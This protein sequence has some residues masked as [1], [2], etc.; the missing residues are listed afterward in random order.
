MNDLESVIDTSDQRKILNTFTGVLSREAH[1]L[2]NNPSLLWQQ[3]HNRLQ[4]EDEQI[5][6]IL[7]EERIQRSKP[8]SIPW[9]WVKTPYRESKERMLTISGEFKGFSSCAISPDGSNLVASGNDNKLYLFDANSGKELFALNGHT[10][11]ISDC[12][13]SP[14]GTWF[15]SASYDNTIKIWDLI[16]GQELRTFTGHTS[17]VNCCVIGP[18]GRS[19]LSGS[20]DDTLRIWD[21]ESGKEIRS[22]KGHTL[23]RGG[24]R[25]VPNGCTI[26]SDGKY[27]VSACADKTIRIFSVESGDEEKMLTGHTNFVVACSFSPDN[28]RIV[29]ASR[30]K[31][32]RIWDVETGEELNVL[33]GHV[34]SVRDCVVS[35]D[36]KK[37]VSSSDDNNLKIW[38]I[39]T[40]KCIRTLIGHSAT[41]TGCA[42]SP[43]GSWILSSS[44][45]GTVRIWDMKMEA[46]NQN[47]IGHH[48]GV[49]D[50]AFSPDGSWFV[51]SGIDESIKIWDSEN[52]GRASQTIKEMNT[53]SCIVSKDSSKIF[54]A[55]HRSLMIIDSSSGKVRSLIKGANNPFTVSPD[56]QWIIS[57]TY[58]SNLKKWDA[59]TGREIFQFG[60]E[61]K[62]SLIC[63]TNPNGTKLV[64]VGKDQSI[65]VWDVNSG[66]ILLELKDHTSSINHCSFSLDGSSIVSAS[67]DNS[68]K[69][70]DLETGENKKEFIL[71]NS[72]TNCSISPD[73][74]FLIFTDTEDNLK[75]LDIQKGKELI[76]VPNLGHNSIAIHPYK[77]IAVCADKLGGLALI[78]FM[79]L[80]FHP[81]M[82]TPIE[83][84][85]EFKIKCPSCHIE[86]N[87]KSI[88][89]GK[90]FFCPTNSCD[91]TLLISNLLIK[92][93][94][95][96]QVQKNV[97]E[98][99]FNAP[100]IRED[101]QGFGTLIEI[102]AGP[103]LMGT[104]ENDI[105]H[106]IKQF[107][108]YRTSIFDNEIPQHIVELSTYWI[109]KAPITVK[110]FFEFIQDSFYRWNEGKE[111]QKNKNHPFVHVNWMDINSFCEWLTQK[112][113]S[114]RMI[115]YDEIVRIPSEAEWEKAA[116]GPFVEGQEESAKRIFPW[117]NELPTIN[118]CNF[119]K[120]VMTTSVK[121]RNF[122]DVIRSTTPVGE[123]S[124][125]GD[126]PYGCVD[127]AGNVWE[128][129]RSLWGEKM[130]ESEFLYPYNPK[131][132]REVINPDK[133]L[134]IRG[135]A[136]HDQAIRIRVTSRDNCRLLH[137][138]PYR[139]SDPWNSSLGFRIVVGREW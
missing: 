88:E 138:D 99:V 35:P 120:N 104:D 34:D 39:D 55:D 70:W 11:T 81:I 63:K 59:Q 21:V 97:L 117:G 60:D 3:M 94:N 28:K 9:A 135:G 14:D 18:N 29:S 114:S 111:K 80:K 27:I 48:G 16:T 115:E 43:D 75:I 54:S 4:W 1:V 95:L 84:E 7:S 67:N 30:D 53:G 57:G 85:N 83:E 96:K 23:K 139:S 125:Q 100:R 32:L 122:G 92:K 44:E 132:G 78:Y 90:V 102:P 17:I 116:R 40:G 87:I 62:E 128:W 8:M 133:A 107:P 69:F 106:L 126:S 76:C 79:G 91:L 52:F 24:Y 47:I 93:Q 89:L 127:M 50:S 49:L 36:G 6:Q 119:G 13:V 56:D 131:D 77:S 65:R 64:T 121:S 58:H 134:V 20:S 123:Y 22:F 10:N 129:T 109:G 82:V 42:V 12:A 41:V 33:K 101:K 2:K 113:R 105:E 61:S 51:T 74:D 124:P 112:W 19:V 86:H 98:I 103:F 71:K 108:G 73:G 25:N 38:D 31:T 66:E 136:F 45:D 5:G 15:A 68:I 37:I 137:H 130:F 46:E 72:V 110:Q 118:H 26:S